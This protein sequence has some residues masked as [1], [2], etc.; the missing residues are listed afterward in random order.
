LLNLK[1][2]TSSSFGRELDVLRNILVEVSFLFLTSFY[3]LKLYSA[4]T[5]PRKYLWIERSDVNSG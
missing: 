3:L 1:H 4:Y 2:E 5:M